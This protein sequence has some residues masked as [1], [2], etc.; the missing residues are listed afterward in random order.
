MLS[1]ERDELILM[2][3]QERLTNEELS[4]E[5]SSLTSEKQALQQEKEYLT[6]KVNI[7]SSIKV[8]DISAK[9]N[10]SMVSRFVL[11]QQPTRW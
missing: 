11:I 4:A 9:P 8:S 5:K 6:G 1:G 2:V 7:A 10:P 3:Q